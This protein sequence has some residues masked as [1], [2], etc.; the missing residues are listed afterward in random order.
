MTPTEPGELLELAQRVVEDTPSEQAECLVMGGARALTR[1]AGNRIHQNVAE[2]DVRASI[3][4]VLDGRTGVASTNR[5][6]EESLEACRNAALAGARVAPADPDFPGLPACGQSEPPD[7]RVASTI[8]FGPHERAVAAGAMIAQSEARG[9]SA[10]GKIE[11]SDTT[12]AVANSFGTAAAMS[13]A[14]VAA[15]VLSTGSDGGSGWA[16][17]AFA[18]AADLAPDAMGAQAA[19]LACRSG[20]PVELAPGR[21]AALL[22]PDA[23]ATLLEYLAYVSF[24][25]KAVHEG[26]SF[27]AGRQGQRVLS[28]SVTISDDATAEDAMG[29]VFDYEG[30]PKARTAIIDR[31]IVVAPVTDSYWAARTG[32]RNTGH[33]L[34][35]PNTLGPM[36]LD[37]ELEPGDMSLDEMLL[38]VDRGILV[39]RFHYVNVEE[40]SRAVLTGMTR[41]GTFLVENGRIGA[42]VRNLRFTQSAVDAL[43]GVLAVERYRRHVRT[44]IGTCKVPSLLLGAFEITGQTG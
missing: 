31:G 5:L 35:A 14:D 4:T 24:S 17:A 37:L 32:S 33:A 22:A 20:S 18:D 43:A 6:D 3:R 1:F 8:G 9:L 36:P 40:P 29:L 34:P 39:T 11:V 30:V 12:V 27:M 25:A 38:S 2:Y 44:G 13:V 23:V 16:A 28:E 15:T 42:P 26:T 7:R 19:D 21:Y 10:A 41:D